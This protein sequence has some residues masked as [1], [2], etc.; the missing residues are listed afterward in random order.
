M[1]TIPER[2]YSYECKA[3]A[4]ERPYVSRPSRSQQFRN[5]KLVP[6]LTNETLNPLE[7]KKGVADEEL[8]KLEAER[9]REREREQRDDELIEPNAKRRGRHEVEAP[10]Q[11]AHSVAGELIAAV[12]VAVAAAV[13]A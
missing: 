7:Q 10:I 3:T 4:Q 1:L 2:H 6:K 8:A 11:R 9:A 12:A 13:L 5:P